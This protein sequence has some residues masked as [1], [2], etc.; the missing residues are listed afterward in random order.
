MAAAIM[1]I[2]GCSD[3]PGDEAEPR[4]ADPSSGKLA[5]LPA[6][7]NLLF[8]VRGP[9]EVSSGRLTVDT[10]TV[11][12]FTDRPRRRAGVASVSELAKRWGGYGFAGDPP[13]AALA[14]P[15]F[16]TVVELTDPE[17]TDD[18]I[19]FDFKPLRGEL[20][21][22]DVE[23][24]EE[25]SLFID[26]GPT[27]SCEKESVDNASACRFQFTQSASF[28]V[29]SLA[30]VA[31]SAYNMGSSCNQFT[32]SDTPILVQAWGG[33]G[34]KGATWGLYSGGSAGSP[35]YAQSAQPYGDVSGDTWYAYVGGG[36]RHDNDGGSGAMASLVLNQPL[37]QISSGDISSAVVIAGGGGG[38]GPANSDGDGWGGG[39][40]GRAWA[41]GDAS[42]HGGSA[43]TGSN[44]ANAFAPG[45]ST[46]STVA[47]SYNSD[48]FE[49]GP[50]CGSEYY[51]HAEGNA[52]A[53]GGSLAVDSNQISPLVQQY[54][55]AAQA[56]VGGEQTW[57]QDENEAGDGNIA[58]VG[59]DAPDE[60]MSYSNFEGGTAIDS[61]LASANLG[62][63]GD[64]H[65]GGAGG[66]GGY[67]GGG[68]SG[69]RYTCGHAGV[70]ALRYCGGA[71][72]G[73]YAAGSSL[74]S[75]DAPTDWYGSLYGSGSSKVEVWIVS[76]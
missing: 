15:N 39:D 29:E 42:S 66:G 33:G 37:S 53:C 51:D 45:A 3:G 56:G 60:K 21:P 9:A 5:A 69:P 57:T 35:G 24:L 47:T 49:E 13:N 31:C 71:G 30:Q 72:G 38:G 70:H 26:A 22:N 17:M 52:Y 64:G 1:L 43:T 63:G 76:G 75:D 25:L 40:G 62:T 50:G 73:S 74:G 44:P 11:E 34:G 4:A 67:G 46:G 36:G 12:W 65:D 27:P 20:A 61:G 14:G 68:G 8:V 16:D 19:A 58:P 7:G 18:G 23:E 54:Y 28:S 6:A 59:G 10:E 41:A 2:A 32:S 48:G 55:F